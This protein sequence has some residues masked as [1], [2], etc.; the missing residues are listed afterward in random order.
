ML[1]RRLVSFVFALWLILSLSFVLIYCL[2]GDPARIILG[3]LASAQSIAEFRNQ[4][5]L[6]DSLSVQYGHYMQ[7]LLA[8]DFGDSIAFR[9]PVNQMLKERGQATFLLSIGATAFMLAYGFILPLLLELLRYDG[10]LRLFDRSI[11]VLALAPPYVLAIAGLLAGAGW[12]GWTN[13]IFD[14]STVTAWIL[15]SIA[16]GAYPAALVFRL[17]SGRLADELKAAYTLNARALGMSQARIVLIEILPNALPAALA[18]VANSL[19]YFVTGAFF[20][21]VVFGIPGWGR[22]TQEALR[23][24][25]V[26]ILTGLCLAFAVIVLCLSATLDVIQRAIDPRVRKSNAHG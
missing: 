9:R 18:A 24:K 12:L 1:L 2:P 17:F 22:L 4:A 11:A 7:R 16:L 21:E 19:A 20:V 26:A 25:D 14:G 5:G 13:V 23:N 3:P 6:D 15:P 10:I 8:L